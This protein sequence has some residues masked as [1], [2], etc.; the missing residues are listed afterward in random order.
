MIEFPTP[1]TVGRVFVMEAASY[2]SNDYELLC[3]T[4]SG[5]P[6]LGRLP[7]TSVTAS[8]NTPNS[9]TDESKRPMAKEKT[10]PRLRRSLTEREQD[11]VSRNPATVADRSETGDIQPGSRRGVF[12]EDLF[13]WRE[14]ER[15]GMGISVSNEVSPLV[16]EIGLTLGRNQTNLF[17]FPVF[18]STAC[19]SMILNICYSGFTGVLRVKTEV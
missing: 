16:K 9:A 15:K 12:L 10:K 17:D 5:K 1:K 2:S 19:F 6:R 8:R 11:R 3:D 4:G 18:Q 13:N 14:R 7:L